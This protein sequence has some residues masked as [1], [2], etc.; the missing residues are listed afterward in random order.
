MKVVCAK[1]KLT[2]QIIIILAKAKLICKIILISLTS[3]K[4]TTV[5]EAIT[6]RI[7]NEFNVLFSGIVCFKG[8]FSLQVQCGMDAATH[9]KHHQ[10]EWLM[11]YKSH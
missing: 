10:E 1:T 7:H 2:C 3:K 11:L 5:S 9:I 8:T 6:T 4:Q